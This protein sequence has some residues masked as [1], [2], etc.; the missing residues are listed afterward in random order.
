ML[1]ILLF[2]TSA[3]GKSIKLMMNILRDY[4][5]QSG[6][7]INKEKSAFLVYHKTAHAHIRRWRNVLV[8]MEENFL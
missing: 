3:D 2:F 1:L 6:R 5:D 4:E 7:M 8:L